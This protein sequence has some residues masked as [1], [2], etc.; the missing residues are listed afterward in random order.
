MI[1][2]FS[3]TGNSLYVARQL[4]VVIK[5]EIIS[6]NEYL[7][8]DK[9]KI[10]NSNKPFIIVAPTHAWRMPRIIESFIKESNFNGNKKIYFILTCGAD[11]GNAIGYAK[12]SI[13]KKGMTFMGLAS[14]IMP[15]NYVALYDSDDRKHS[16]EIIRKA[17]PGILDIA[18]KI[19]NEK[20]LPNKPISLLDKIKSSVTNPIFYS[21]IVS[22]KGFHTNNA[23]ISCSKCVTLC[24]L[25][26]IQMNDTKPQW[27]KNCIHCM[28]CIGG[29]PKG[30]IEYKNRTVGKVRYYN[31][32]YPN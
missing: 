18:Q 31:T 1:L 11:V 5:D 27:G 12:K 28:A 19:K 15:D 25:N 14:I 29:C 3:G 4:N 21:T 10:F 13:D 20:E 16:K 22:A 26:N 9:E 8:E 6:I 7:K 30:A 2:C 24:P 23:C 17:I 32:E